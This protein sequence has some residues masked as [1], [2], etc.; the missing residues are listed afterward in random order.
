MAGELYIGGHGV[1]RGYVNAPDWTAGK[2]IP[3]PFSRRPG[4]RL[5]STG[6]V[7]HY[8]GDG[9]IKYLG[10]SDHQV[11]LR[12]HRI[13][14][15]E[16]EAALERHP[17]I[18]QAAVE[19]REDSRDEKFLV[20]YGVVKSGHTFSF[21][22][23]RGFLKDQLPEHMI[24]TN[25]L[26]LDFMPLTP[27]GK[28]DRKS[29][30]KPE[31]YG[32]KATANFDPPRTPIEQVLAGV[33]GEVLGVD[34]VGIHDNFFEIGG[35]SILA[36]Q[37]TSRLRDIFQSE[38]PLRSFLEAPTIAEFAGTMTRNAQEAARVQRIAELALSIAGYSDEEAQVMLDDSIVPSA[39]ASD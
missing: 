37:V 19:L 3:D 27:N 32:G 39:Q 7:T 18:S 2:F 23:M 6:D 34:Q 12:G 22:E 31:R 13:E 17:V 25:L 5:Y 20:A 15:V 1:A 21:A 16:I 26:I 9:T 11:K 8:L 36:I 24:P 29:L 14:I 38:F 28:I 10:R 30:P 4:R 33:W 35:H